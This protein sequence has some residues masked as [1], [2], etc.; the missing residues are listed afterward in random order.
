MKNLLPSLGPGARPLI[1]VV[2]G[3]VILA[4]I[5]A[6]RGAEQVRDGR[7]DIRDAQPAAFAPDPEFF[8][9]MLPPQP[10]DW[11]AGPGRNERDRTFEEYVKSNPKGPTRRRTSI[12]I[13]PLGV[14]SREETVL[15][16]KLR[17]YC[18]IFFGLPARIEE[19][20][21]LPETGRRRRTDGPR[22]FDQFLTTAIMDELLRPNLPDDAICYL[23][24][25][26]QDLYPEPD[27]NFV[28]GQA[29]LRERVG[30]Y[31]LARYRPEF[32]GRRAD[33]DTDKLILMRAIKVMVHETGH[34]FGLHHC[35]KWR[36][37]MNGSNHLA[38]SDRCPVFLCPDCLRKLRW[39]LRF[40]IMSRYEGMARFWARE[41]FEEETQWSRRRIEKLR[42]T[43][44]ARKQNGAER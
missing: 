17:A 31:S 15:I 7:A 4:G 29:S 20:R 21:P 38:E 27:W 5:V 22:G 12:V 8:N 18:A 28:F 16:E 34:M 32:Y 24:V 19:P 36:C 11:L 2:T 30:V 33:A 44:P 14:F 42:S 23:G 43:P 10:G 13:Q 37:V 26:M 3:T 25:T 41:G 40:D 9:P 6:W 1:M 35:R 39:N